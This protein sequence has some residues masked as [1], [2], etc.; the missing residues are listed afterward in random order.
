MLVDVPGGALFDELRAK[1]KDMPSSGGSRAA[2][3]EQ[4]ASYGLMSLAPVTST[5]AR[6]SFKTDNDSCFIC[7]SRDRYDEA[8]FASLDRYAKGP[9]ASPIAAGLF[10]IDAIIDAPR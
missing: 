10:D 4:I 1:A 7:P 3:P 9:M 6:V 8:G 5:E 2:H